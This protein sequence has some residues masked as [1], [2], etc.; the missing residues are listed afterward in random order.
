MKLYD[1]KEWLIRKYLDEKI[2]INELGRITGSSKRTVSKRLKEWGINI[3]PRIEA[4]KLATKGKKLPGWHLK[5]L[6][7]SHTGENHHS[8]NGGK[9]NG[10]HGYVWILKP[11]HPHCNNIGYVLEH[12]LTIEKAIGRYLSPIEVVHHINDNETDNRLVNL[13]LFRS[14]I[15]HR[16]FHGLRN[17][18]PNAEM[19]YSYE[20]MDEKYHKFMN[21]KISRV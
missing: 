5:K 19:K 11:D 2:S 10:N 7:E 20:V 12:R 17:K 14:N 1:K 13:F 8:W 15:D 18:N 21:K 9:I 4:C 6:N 3:R 16:H